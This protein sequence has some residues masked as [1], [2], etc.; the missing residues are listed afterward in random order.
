MK[1][2]KMTKTNSTKTQSTSDHRIRSDL[3]VKKEAL[4]RLIDEISALDYVELNTRM[5]DLAGGKSQIIHQIFIEKQGNVFVHPRSPSSRF[6]DDEDE[7]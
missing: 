7:D 3:E 4:H 2:E 1:K 6:D 5:V